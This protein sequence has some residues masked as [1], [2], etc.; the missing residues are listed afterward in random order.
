MT[1]KKV[2][3][4]GATGFIGS[5]LLDALV[6]RNQD[7]RCLVERKSDSEHLQRKG[8][9]LVYGDLADKDSLAPAVEGVDVIYHLAAI[10]SYK[11][12][13]QEKYELINYGGTRE[14]LE[15]A[16]NRQI[17]KFI[18]FS[19]IG[20]VG[21]LNEPVLLDEKA[22][23][24][25]LSPY[26]ISKEKAERTVFEYFNKY[27]LPAV[28]IRP[29]KVYGPGD[30]SELLTLYRMVQKGLFRFVG[31]M[32]KIRMSFCY[33]GNLV[34]ASIMAEENDA[35]IGQIYFIS[36]ERPYSLEEFV[37]AVAEEENVKLP[38]KD[39]PL[40]M[41]KL[42]VCFFEKL[43][44]MTGKHSLVSEKTLIRMLTEYQMCDIS[45][46]RK[47][48]NYS[49]KFRLKEGMHYTIDWYKQKGLLG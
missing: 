21:S 7:V 48:L 35:S 36:D 44:K 24:K 43:K 15:S 5:H 30:L 38:K 47:E 25:A 3:V 6:R 11:R 19:S 27:K 17:R 40:W 29:S 33:V 32:R 20:V 2:L 34:E 1:G 16:V 45:K 46:A 49:S 18:Y 41:A 42:G 26:E 13:P 14:L 8:I 12:A 4:T 9:E 23:Y 37:Q 10:Q 22:P 28:V 39:I 31:N